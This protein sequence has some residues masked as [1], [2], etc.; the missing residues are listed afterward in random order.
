[1][2][3]TVLRCLLAAGAALALSTAARAQEPVGGVSHLDG[4][5]IVQRRLVPAPAGV[6]A[7]LVTGDELQTADSRAEVTF[8]DGTLMH[9]DAFTR[10]ALHERGRFQ[11]IDGRIFIR[12]SSISASGYLVE[13]AAARLWLMPR[14]IYGIMTAA[15]Q[16]DA[17]LRVVIG[18][19]R[20]ESRWGFETVAAHRTAFVSGPTGRPFVSVYVPPFADPFENWSAARTMMATLGPGSPARTVEELERHGPVIDEYREPQGV[21]Y[22]T[23]Y[24]YPSGPYARGRFDGRHH[25]RGDDDAGRGDRDGD[26]RGRAERARKGAREEEPPVAAPR[27]AA[28]RAS[29]PVPAVTASVKG[30]GLP[31]Q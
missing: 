18:E 11:V 24:Y 4:P 25:P 13:T 5:L 30:A 31:R 23:G 3:V 20:I 28:P 12:T 2:S 22:V 1:M 14:G 29:A 10:V 15:R 21:E 27:P 6:G 19:S 8:L 26:R 17:L 16:R 7:M 9:L